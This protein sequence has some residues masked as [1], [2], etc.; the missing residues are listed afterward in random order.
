M[1]LR[2][3]FGLTCSR[4]S[5]FMMMMMIYLLEVR[6]CQFVQAEK[7]GP[8]IEARS[9]ALTAQARFLGQRPGFPSSSPQT[10][11]PRH[12]L[13][14]PVRTPVPPPT[15]LSA[16]CAWPF[17]LAV[18]CASWLL[19]EQE[20]FSIEVRQRCVGFQYPRA[21]RLQPPPALSPATSS[22]M[23]IFFCVHAT[24]SVCHVAPGQNPMGSDLP[25]LVRKGALTVSGSAPSPCSVL[26]S[27]PFGRRH[28]RRC[29]MMI[30]SARS[31]RTHPTPRNCLSG[32][33]R[34]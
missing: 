28:H 2:L 3:C 9:G 22:S 24:V 12:S 8:R 34:P 15:P 4:G 20:G 29:M 11:W 33:Y 1:F 10:G 31:C 7:R 17:S 32:P 5:S 21:G 18:C 16:S 27:A 14:P 26:G 19:L 25:P 23:M 6:R 30:F 13:M